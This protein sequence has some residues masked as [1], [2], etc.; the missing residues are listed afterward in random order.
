MKRIKAFA[1]ITL[2]FLCTVAFSCHPDVKTESKKKNER[3]VTY[4]VMSI[5]QYRGSITMQGN[6]GTGY[7]WDEDSNK[8]F[9]RVKLTNN[10]FIAVDAYGRIIELVQR[11][12]P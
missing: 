4:P 2:F 10:G 3:S 7:L 8:L 5:P 1:D 6:T 11:Q 9:V 12:V